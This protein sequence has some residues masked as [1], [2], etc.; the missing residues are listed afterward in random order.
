MKFIKIINLK[1]NIKK[2]EDLNLH[3]FYVYFIIL[4]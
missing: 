3:I 1:F 2:Y 4:N